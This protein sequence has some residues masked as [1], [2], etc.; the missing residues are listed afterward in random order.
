MTYQQACELTE[1]ITGKGERQFVFYADA[2]KFYWTCA[3]QG[4]RRV[5]YP[6]EI[7]SMWLV[8]FTK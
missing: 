8:V 1:K 5:D 2:V 4:C 3:A 7:N 6:V